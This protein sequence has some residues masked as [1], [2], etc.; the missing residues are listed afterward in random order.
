MPFQGNIFREEGY[1]RNEPCARMR[2]ALVPPNYLKQSGI[3]SN[4]SFINHCSGQFRQT[5]ATHRVHTA[6]CHLLTPIYKKKSLDEGRW[7]L[8]NDGEIGKSF[9][10][11]RGARFVSTRYI[12]RLPGAVR[13]FQVQDTVR[14]GSMMVFVPF[15]SPT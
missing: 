2:N 15:G 11:E 5:L 10:G 13:Y 9:R 1:E 14:K 7:K 12:L 6:Y 8:T 4:R 3:R